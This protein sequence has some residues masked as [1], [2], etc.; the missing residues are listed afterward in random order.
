MLSFALLGCSLLASPLVGCAQQSNDPPVLQ[1]STLADGATLEIP[2]LGVSIAV[3]ADDP[4][5]DDL[6]FRWAVDGVGVQGED[7]RHTSSTTSSYNAYG[8]NLDGAT[9]SCTITD[10]IDEIAISWPMVY[11]GA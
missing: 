8:E 4:N 1:T 5:G 9:L 11:T 7:V 6:Q 3:T 2:T 10:F